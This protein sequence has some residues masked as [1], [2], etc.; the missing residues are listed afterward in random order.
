MIDHYLNESIM[1]KDLIEYYEKFYN[2]IIILNVI[3]EECEKT[4]ID[5][6]L[7]TI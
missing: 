7:K 6:N 5:P 4:K 1:K 3:T 2:E